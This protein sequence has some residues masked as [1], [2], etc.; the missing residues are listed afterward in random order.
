MKNNS[1]IIS[2]LIIGIVLT[3]LVFSP[4]TSVRAV[5]PAV[6]PIPNILAV[7]T[8]DLAAGQQEYS[9]SLLDALYKVFVQTLKRQIIGQMV[10]QIVEWIQGNG[11]PKFVTDWKGLL[12]DAGQA[13]AGEFA[14]EVGLGFLCEPFSAQIQISLF[15]IKKFSKKAECTLDK[16]VGNINNFREDFRNGGWIAYAES[17]QPQNN[18]FG[19]TLMAKSEL[20]R[21][22]ESA[23]GASWS[24]ALAGNGF[25]S[26]KQC[27]K[28]ANGKV[29]ESTC[30]ITTPGDVVGKAV[31]KAVGA[32][33][34]FI[35]NATDV[36]EIA[37]TIVNALVNRIITEGVKGLAGVN[38]PSAPS[39][40][41]I[42][43]G[44]DNCGSLTGK[45]LEACQKYRLTFGRNFALSQL[46]LIQQ[47]DL[48]LQPNIAIKTTI[49]DSIDTLQTYIN[50]AKLAYDTLSDL[51]YVSICKGP[52]SREDI[53]RT[54]LMANID[55]S[56][57]QEESLIS[58]LKID[59]T[60]NQALVNELQNT[61]NQINTLSSAEMEKMISIFDA[62]AGK[63]DATAAENFKSTISAENAAID[64][65]AQANLDKFD[66][67]VK[68]CQASK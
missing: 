32:D 9:Q 45:S 56:I 43:L 50:W 1:A 21:R 15:P 17:W 23:S 5:A 37:A 48:T 41:T 7:P 51:Q 54:E 47:I 53:G 68:T 29:I 4:V 28:D 13:A 38:P 49:A 26:T 58:R 61:E 57:K 34:D 19:A 11:K 24:E 63:L 22:Q 31:G 44:V 46:G 52:T 65:R 35:V 66:K 60:N 33:F 36:E 40:G 2:Y 10:D 12:E 55:G 25:L 59:Q 20:N 64:N 30:K 62:V 42:D 27:Q 18:I 6:P 39:G 16:I 3:M 8:Q 14:K 67:Q